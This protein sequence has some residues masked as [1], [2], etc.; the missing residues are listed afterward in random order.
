MELL[1][2]PDQRSGG[3]QIFSMFYFR[4]MDAISIGDGTLLR[5]HATFLSVLS[6]EAIF[7]PSTSNEHSMRAWRSQRTHKE[8][9]SI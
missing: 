3:I 6:M 4:G 1:T 7:N 8:R 9:V 5:R 2:E